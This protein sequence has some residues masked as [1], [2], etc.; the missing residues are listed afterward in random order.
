[1]AASRRKAEDAQKRRQ[2]PGELARHH[3]QPE[4][5]RIGE[6]ARQQAAHHAVGNGRL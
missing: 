3:R 5:L 2:R 4:Q 1:M 6:H